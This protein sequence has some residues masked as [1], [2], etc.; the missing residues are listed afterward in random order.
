M[1]KIY[2]AGPMSGI[3]EFNFPAFHE[4]TKALRANG[5]EVFNPAERDFEVH[6]TDISVGNETGSVE[7]AAKEHGFSKRR[8]LGDDL[9][10]ICANADAIYML[11]GWVYSTGAAAEFATATALDIK[12]FFGNVEKVKPEL[13]DD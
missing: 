8:A 2:V 10:W 1:K 5:W 13:L 7:E 11:P 3:K 4:A 6:G 9:A 12:S